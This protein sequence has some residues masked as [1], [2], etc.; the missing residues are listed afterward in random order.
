MGYL[1][2]DVETAREL[3]IRQD[4]LP[5]TTMSAALALAALRA[6]PPDVAPT[7]AERGWLADRLRGLRLEPLPSHT[8]FLYVPMPAARETYERLLRRG[9]VVRPSDDA[10]RITVHTREANERL[11]AA[12]EQTDG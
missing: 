4:P 7:I 3:R 8:N 11:L 2:A 10:I 6:G 1:V 9:F 12:L 5:I